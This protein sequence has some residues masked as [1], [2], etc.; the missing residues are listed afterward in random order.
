MTMAEHEFTSDPRFLEAV[1]HV[2]SGEWARAAQLF[3]ELIQ[4]YPQDGDEL[5]PLLDDL[6]R[7]KHLAGQRIRGRG[8]LSI[9]LYNRQFLT[10]VAIALVVVFLLVGGLFIVR[11]WALPALESRQTMALFARIL[12]QAQAA[13]AR[14]DYAAAI[15]SYQAALEIQPDHPTAMEGL[16]AAKERLA[17]QQ[18]YAEAL[19]RLERGESAKALALFRDIQ[20]RAPGYRDVVAQIERIER[21]AELAG[22]FAQAEAHFRAGEWEAAIQGYE[23]IRQT[24]VTFNQREVEERLFQSLI[25]RA[26]ELL[27]LPE[28]LAADIRTA[29]SL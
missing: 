1:R 4:A 28:P 24:D 26:E 12:D 16:A 9:Y 17:L 3:Q 8:V 15:Q 14:G 5:K 18:Q 27:H 29:A 19:A 2:Q 13:M 25:H 23:T 11:G 6:K 20:Q 10:R 7:K 21:N 22:L